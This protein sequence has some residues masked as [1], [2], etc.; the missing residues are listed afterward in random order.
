MI[1]QDLMLRVLQDA[2]RDTDLVVKKTRIRSIQ[3]DIHQSVLECEDHTNI[4]A[5]LVIGC[6]GARSS[7]RQAAGIGMVMHAYDQSGIV[8][9]LGLERD[10]QG[11]AE[12]HFL[13]SGP[14]A[15]LPLKGN[16]CSL[17]WTER[18]DRLDD[19][20][21][22]SADEFIAEIEDRFGLRYGALTLLD[23]PRAY[24]L[25]VGLAREFVKPRLALVGDAAHV[26]HPIS[27]QGLNLG[28]RDVAALV[29]ILVNAIRLGLDFGRLQVLQDYER[30]RRFDTL[31]M[32]GVTDSLNRLFSNDLTP[33]RLFRDLGLGIVDRMPAVKD[34]L[35]REAA[36]RNPAAPKLMQGL[37]P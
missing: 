12:E 29:E 17:V 7:L 32:A 1:E 31:V 35:I 16:R 9:T 20:L 36:I 18:N 2:L 8:A 23:Q 30:A 5:R 14:F 24:P 33:V 28:L 21:S 27:G 4:Q 3:T 15:T 6:D 10:H 19:Y 11:V 13:P 37:V 25:R 22:M 34:L 26:V